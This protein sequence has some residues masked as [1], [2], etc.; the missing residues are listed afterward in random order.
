M[1]DS[2]QNNDKIE[3]VNYVSDEALSGLYN[4]CSFTVFPSIEEGFG[5]PILESL[6]HGKPVIC[7]NFG[8]PAEVAKG[9]GCL[10]IDTLSETDMETALE[11]MVFDKDM[12]NKLASEA[13]SRPMKTRRD[14]SSEIISVLNSFENPLCRIKKIYYWIDHTRTYP[15]NSG[16]QRVTRMLARALQ[17]IN[18]QLVPVRWNSRSQTFCSAGEEDLLHLAKWNGPDPDRFSSFSTPEEGESSWLLIPELT[19]Y[20]E[21]HDLENV[22][23]SAKSRGL[24]TAIIFYDALPYKLSQLYPAEATKAHT[25]YMKK[26]LHFDYVLPISN[27]SLSDLKNFLF[28]HED[29]LTNIE[30][31]LHEVLLPGEFC[32]HPRVVNYKEPSSSIIRILCVGTIEPRKNHLTL[33]ESFDDLTNNRAIN[34]ELIMIGNCP[35]P[36]LEQKVNAF[37]KKNKRIHWLRHTDDTI[38]ASEYEKCH[39]TIYPSIDEGFGLPIVESLWHGRPCICRNTSAMMEAAEGGGCLTV[40]TTSV[41][42]LHEAMA[43]LAQDKAFRGKLGQEAIT[44][45][46]KTWDAYAWEIL[47]LLA[48][49]TAK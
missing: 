20:L 32:E 12:L 26:L 43:L 28:S 4:K 16:I 3:Y 49:R 29:K 45:N 47:D 21:G 38:L 25:D 14:Y 11:Q 6:W 23:K 46:I 48:R 5:L 44:R 22:I 10:T 37:L 40:D 9:G 15:A 17:Q 35:F 1:H 31:K 24:Q 13:I 39:F 27:T 33:L 30:A 36:E 18:I 19:T 2:M 41:Q 8:A 7:A 34:A 42:E